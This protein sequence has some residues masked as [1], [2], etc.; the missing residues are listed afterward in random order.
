MKREDGRI[1][2]ETGAQTESADLSYISE[3]PSLAA[4]FY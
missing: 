4:T 1:A 2:K 3:Y